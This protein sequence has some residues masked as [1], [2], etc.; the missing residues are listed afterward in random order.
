MESSLLICNYIYNR[1]SDKEVGLDEI[2]QTEWNCKPEDMGG[3]GKYWDGTDGAKC[4]LSH[5]TLTHIEEMTGVPGDKSM[6]LDE[7][8]YSI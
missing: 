7:F 3:S 6:T 1:D 4:E 8:R 5:Y 2:N